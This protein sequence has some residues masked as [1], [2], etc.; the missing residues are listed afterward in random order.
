M[1][2]SGTEN[3]LPNIDFS[4]KA[5]E[6]AGEIMINSIDNDEFNGL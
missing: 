5:L 6:G 1:G 2:S 3:L 4:L